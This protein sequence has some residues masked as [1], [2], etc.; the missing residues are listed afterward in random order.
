LKTGKSADLPVF[1]HDTA[2]N[3]LLDA[4]TIPRIAADFRGD[5]G[6]EK[7]RYQRS[8]AVANADDDGGVIEAPLGLA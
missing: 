2:V 8:I 4:Q 5:V 1:R 7:N 3:R 6:E